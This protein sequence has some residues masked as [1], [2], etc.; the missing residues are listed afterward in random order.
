MDTCPFTSADIDAVLFDMDGTLIDTDNTDVSRW[1]RRIARLYRS[2][3]RAHKAA[4]RLVMAIESPTNSIF[5]ALDWVGLDALV[6]RAMIALQGSKH[7]LH[8]IPTING[9]PEIIEKLV[10]RYKLGVVSTRS[11]TEQET[12]LAHLRLRQHFDV[13]VGRDTT[14]RIKPHPQPI[15]YAAH[16][17]GVE[18]GRC[19]MVGDTTVDILAG[20][21][22][23]A[24]TCGV[25]CGYGE[26]IELER[27][28][29]DVIIRETMEIGN[30][31][32]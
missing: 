18:P 6:V 12:L 28:G 20:R 14:W 19:L 31:L 32:S 9:T 13:L 7:S 22:A 5:A 29:A 17:L 15:H 4:R 24:W 27:A 2:P 8:D 1:A 16:A 3:E 30:L 25:L 10:G 26:R 23:G 11:I 21:R